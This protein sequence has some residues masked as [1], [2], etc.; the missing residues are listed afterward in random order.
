MIIEP[1]KMVTLTY[2]LTVKNDLGTEEISVQETTEKDPFIFLFGAGQ[3]IPGFEKAIQGKVA[4]DLFDFW[5]PA[6]EAYGEKKQENIIPFPIE[7][8]LDANGQFDSENIKVGNQI[9]LMDQQGNQFMATVH[10]IG[11]EKV[12]L[13]FNHELAG[14]DLHFRGKV[15]HVRQATREELEDYGFETF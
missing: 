14:K 2:H 13:D 8:F 15:V 5:I 7:H 6:N 4:G 1:Q 11:L 10:H 9:T 3:L 12:T